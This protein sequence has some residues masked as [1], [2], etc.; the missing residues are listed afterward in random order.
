MTK[1]YFTLQK[2]EIMKKRYI[3]KFP[4]KNISDPITYDLVKIYDLKINILNADISSGRQGN[5]VLEFDAEEKNIEAGVK[6]LEQKGIM[7]SPMNKQLT[8][9][10]DDCVACGSCTAVCFSGALEM[11]KGN[12]TLEFD[13]KKC[14]VCG[15]CVKACPMQLFEINIGDV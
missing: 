15:R 13:A 4:Q 8:F 2:L 11:D 3:L 5:L 6:Y 9:K 1:H 7:C 10:Q 12:W 14:V